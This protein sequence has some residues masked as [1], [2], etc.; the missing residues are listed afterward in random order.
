MKS[1]VSQAREQRGGTVV[2]TG[3]NDLGEFFTGSKKLSSATGEEKVIEAPIITFT[4]DDA[5]GEL[6]NV[7][8]G[9]FDEV[10]VRQRITVEGGENNNQSSQFYG[11]VNFTQK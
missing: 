1:L 5:Q 6:S 2:Y 8:N 10:L 7:L 11:P 3:M 4:G 9:I